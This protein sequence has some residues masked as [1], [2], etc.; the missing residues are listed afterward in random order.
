MKKW[1]GTCHVFQVDT[2][3]GKTWKP[4][5]DTSA[6]LTVQISGIF[7]KL[8]W[9]HRSISLVPMYQQYDTVEFQLKKIKENYIKTFQ[10]TDPTQEIELTHE[11]IV[12][13]TSAKFVQLN[14]AENGQVF[15]FGFRKEDDR[16]TF[17]NIIQ[18]MC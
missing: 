17:Q 3:N 14:A 18:V 2:S 11:S 4:L 12:A 15:G 7:S 1:N 13:C 5:C 10:E 16:Q 8:S 6:G 9:Y